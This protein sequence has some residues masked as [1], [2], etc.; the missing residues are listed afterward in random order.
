MPK[1]PIT[2]PNRA[3]D[4]IAPSA[5]GVELIDGFVDNVGPGQNVLQ[6]RGGL[7]MW[8]WS[9]LSS[10][11]DGLH[12][13]QEKKRLIAVIGGNIYA[14]TNMTDTPIQVNPASVALNIGEPAS[15]A[16]SG[17]WLMVTTRG[18]RPIIWN[19]SAAG[20]AVV[21]VGSP[22]VDSVSWTNDNFLMTETGSNRVHRATA[23]ANSFDTPA[24]QAGQ[25]FNP[26]SAPDELICADAKFG[27]L[28][29]F[30]AR[31]TEFWGYDPSKEARLV[32]FSR[33]QGVYF[34]HG[35]AAP[36]TLCF[37]ENTHL[38]LNQNKQVIRLAGRNPQVI[39]QPFDRTLRA[40][41]RIDNARAFIIDNRFYCLC[42]PTDDFC[43]VYDFI[44]QGWYKWSYWVSTGYERFLGNC[45]EWVP[46][47]NTQ[48]VGS[49]KQGRIYIYSRNLV[50][51]A[52]NSIRMSYKTAHNDWG[53]LETKMCEKLLMRLRR[54]V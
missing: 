1:I 53:T 49:R 54:G 43:L 3:S 20:G 8:W 18:S 34:E 28:V 40:M 37:F 50:T 39:S 4:E 52:G 46:E 12:W 11:V 44:S 5:G 16:S 19:G 33:L 51:D 29:L 6:R 15:F 27:E 21:L 42:F 17:S 13:W 24:Y 35:I 9:G 7:W 32:P 2:V 38:W 10:P 30:G 23:T 47:W 14:F 26:D 45:A 36:G 31:S 41:I 22:S 25:F 48:F